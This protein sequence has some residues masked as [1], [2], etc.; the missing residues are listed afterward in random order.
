MAKKTETAAPRSSWFDEATSTPLI[1]QSVPLLDSFIA[2]MTDGRVDAAELKA[3][4]VR[5]VALD[6]RDRAPAR[7]GPP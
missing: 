1:E 5:L 4:E 2:T 6:E 3:Q 7:Y